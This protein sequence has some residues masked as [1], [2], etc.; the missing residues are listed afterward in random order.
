MKEV[1]DSG[2]RVRAARLVLSRPFVLVKA[3]TLHGARIRE[4]EGG[5]EIDVTLDI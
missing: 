2:V 3:A 1:G 5:L 4:V